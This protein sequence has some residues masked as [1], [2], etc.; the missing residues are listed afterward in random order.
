MQTIDDIL[1]SL[2]R[3]GPDQRKRLRAELD[4][5]EQGPA[6]AR[7]EGDLLELAGVGNSEFTDVS[8][9]KAKHLADVYATK[10]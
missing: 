1:Q 9:D 8:S 10:T 7:A 5:L 4:A 2:R 6:E 3:L